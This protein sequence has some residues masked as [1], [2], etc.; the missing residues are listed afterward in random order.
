VVFCAG[1][2]MDPYLRPAVYRTMLE[3]GGNSRPAA[4]TPIFER[5]HEKLKIQCEAWLPHLVRFV[6]DPKLEPPFNPSKPLAGAGFY[7]ASEHKPGVRGCGEF[8]GAMQNF[9][10]PTRRRRLRCLKRDSG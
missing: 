8:T 3:L 10:H 6:I 4:H 9:A 2:D 5:L 7:R 1:F